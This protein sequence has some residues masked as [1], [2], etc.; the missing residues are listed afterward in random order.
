MFEKLSKD[1]SRN[2]Q[3][4]KFLP[5]FF[6][7]IWSTHPTFFMANVLMRLSKALLPVLLLYM[8]KLIID[9][10]VIQMDSYEKSLTNLFFL[11][12]A[13][14]A[15]ILVNQLLGRGVDL[16]DALLGDLY[17]NRS[18]VELITKTAQVE[19][20]QLEDPGFYDKLER[21]RRQ[22]TNRVM[23]MSS[24]LGQLQDMITVISLLSGF[25]FLAPWLLVFLL[26]SIIPSVINE[27]KFSGAGYSLVR[28]WTQERRE[29]DY[30][31]YIGASD[32]TAKEVKL[33]GLADFIAGRFKN[34]SHRYY[35]ANRD[36]AMRR[37]GWGASFT[38][39][40]DLFYLG[41]YIFIIFRTIYGQLTLG[42]L[43]FLSGSFT[44]LRSQLEGMFA[45]YG[46]ITESALFLQDYFEFIDLALPVSVQNL[47]PA[48]TLIKQGFTFEN[49]GF[50]YPQAEQFVLRHL[51]FS[52]KQGEK[53]ALV[54]E[55]GAGKTTLIK[56]LLRMYQPTEGR[57][58]LDGQ[59]IQSFQADSYQKLFG[60]IFQDFVHYYFT[61]GENIGIGK[62]EA[63]NDDER[64]RYAAERSM[65][66]E[67]IAGLPKGLQQP[68]GKRFND[69][70][71][72]SGGQWQK[73]G[74]S[75]AYMKDAECI[76]LDEPTAALDAR[77]E[78]EAYNRF[79]ELTK[80]KTAVIISHR[81]STVRMADRILV[82]KDGS[83]VELG[84]HEALLK[85]HGLY[86]ELFSL[87]A[88]GYQ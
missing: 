48:P 47:S 28:R 45:R 1:W 73:I 70:V 26:L 33:F 41:A 4:W 17:A 27:L 69:G 77:A 3:A 68:L 5:R 80:G 25:M 75:R 10:V 14:F 83:M 63:V 11:I 18:S 43:T 57:I 52:L 60:V 87:Q 12:G 56:L 62:I 9:K 22:T 82:L 78:A 13:E 6:R 67:V 88:R 34:L 38:F 65:A 15:L 39:L 2:K 76:V 8:G 37:A 35:L 66:D 64:L 40:G 55:N 61:A 72:L 59:D 36:L 32:E 84:T 23:L 86:A 71:E 49:V 81:F 51:S 46:A 24:V 74:L 58:L 42:D 50:K 20:S 31:R 7:L 53:L 54:G 30:L 16:T 29:L 19:L 44:R 21:A 85:A 79:I